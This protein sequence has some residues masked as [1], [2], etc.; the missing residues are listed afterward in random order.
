M[1]TLPLTRTQPAS[2]RSL[3][4]VPRGGGTPSAATILRDHIR[5]LVDTAPPL[6]PQQQAVI[7]RA[8]Q[9]IGR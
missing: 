5:A 7:R 3:A 1:N 6:G 9:G 2:S 8:F 4:A